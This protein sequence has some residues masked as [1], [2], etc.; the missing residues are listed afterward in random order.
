VKE[1]VDITIQANTIYFSI[2]YTNFEK[3]FRE[4]LGVDII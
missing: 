1:T 2:G 3:Q 4:V